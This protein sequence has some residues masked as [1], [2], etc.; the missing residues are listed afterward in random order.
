MTVATSG[1]VTVHHGPMVS[2]V[3]GSPGS[4]LTLM[5]DGEGDARAVLDVP[6]LHAESDV[7]A[8]YVDG[9]ADLVR[10]FEGLLADWRGWD[11]TRTWGSVDRTLR[12]HA[13]SG[14]T[15]LVTVRQHPGPE[16]HLPW[17]AAAEFHIDPGE[18]LRRLVADLREW[19]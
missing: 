7:E 19:V 11:G 9:F 17:T 1:G 2:V 16:A 15:L 10:F 8:S 12:V 3:I 14:I 13:T 5:R 6:G 18:D 4:A